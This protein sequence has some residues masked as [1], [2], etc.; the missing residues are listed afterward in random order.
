[1]GGRVRFVILS[2]AKNLER[3]AWS[4][5]FFAF[6]SAQNDRTG[7][8]RVISF[9]HSDIVIPKLAEESCDLCRI[10]TLFTTTLPLPVGQRF[11]GY[12]RND[13]VK[14]LRTAMRDTNPCLPHKSGGKVSATLTDEGIVFLPFPLLQNKEQSAQPSSVPLGHLPPLL[15]GKARVFF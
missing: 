2:K 7:G 11:L 9:R 10:Q 15:R 13:K 1:V 3:M 5:R 14:N 4:L 12:A 8:A 6:V